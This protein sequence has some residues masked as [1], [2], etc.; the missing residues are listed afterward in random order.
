[1]RRTRSGESPASEVRH[2]T[3]GEGIVPTEPQGL[4]AALNPAGQMWLYWDRPADQITATEEE[5]NP[6]GA[7]ILGYYIQGGPVET[8]AT[9]VA[10]TPDSTFKKVNDAGDALVDRLRL[11]SEFFRRSE[12]FYVEAGTDVPL[13]ASVLN[14]LDNFRRQTFAHTRH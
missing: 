4:R 14:R 6:F 5:H 8:T 11:K 1:M 10:V 12:V 7:P 2:Q 13:T 9:A 3:T